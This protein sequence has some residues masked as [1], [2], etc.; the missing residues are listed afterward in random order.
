MSFWT[1][2][3]GILSSLFGKKAPS[4]TPTPVPTPIPPPVIVPPPIVPPIVVPPPVIVPPPVVIPP[5]IVPPTPVP[6]LTFSIPKTGQ[7][8]INYEFICTS[9]NPSIEVDISSAIIGGDTGFQGKQT[10]IP[11]L[12]WQWNIYCK[13]GSFLQVVAQPSNKALETNSSN[14]LDDKFYICY[15]PLDPNAVG[16]PPISSNY[17]YSVTEPLMDTSASE[18]LFYLGGKAVMQLITTQP[19]AKGLMQI[20]GA[21]FSVN[22]FV[23]TIDF[24]KDT[25]LSK[26]IFQIDS[27]PLPPS[28]INAIIP[29]FPVGM[30]PMSINLV[31][32]GAASTVVET[33]GSGQVIYT[34]MTPTGR[35]ANYMTAENSNI[36]YY[37]PVQNGIQWT[38][39]WRVITKTGLL[40]PLY[41][42]PPWPT[43]CAAQVS[44]PNLK[45]IAVINPASGPGIGSDVN[46]VA[47]IEALQKCGI[48]VLGY[49][50]TGYGLD[51]PSAI[52]T[53][54]TNYQTWYKVDGI[55]LD[56]VGIAQPVFYQS[57][58]NS[59]RSLGYKTVVGNPGVLLSP[60]YNGIFDIV[61]VYENAGLPATLESVGN[62]IIAYDVPT[63]TASSVT[64]VAQGVSYLYI[65]DA[66][67]PNP[68]GVLPSYF[69]QLVSIL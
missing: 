30:C 57:L 7:G 62:A 20:T 33:S 9:P 46:Y 43:V 26:Y 27:T 11:S 16:F 22:G 48:T 66:N 39:Q 44:N 4:P 64:T 2:L 18:T 34:G 37:A 13:D 28:W 67:L 42:Y 55:F 49:V 35:V 29:Y 60:S 17:V 41:I 32:L 53:Q 54:M 69:A 45:I 61:V 40:I 24:T 15:F 12:S 56:E 23:Y 31:G 38:S 19:D 68:Y 58:V 36:S 47:G 21:T 65:T 6:S 63:I 14:A 52:A 10:L 1:W 50:P 5:V 8:N 51:T 59:A 25:N 3:I